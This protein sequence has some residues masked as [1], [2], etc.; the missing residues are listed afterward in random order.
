MFSKVVKSNIKNKIAKLLLDN[1]N[2]NFIK[3]Y[4]NEL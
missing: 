4:L 2:Y 3:E 1:D